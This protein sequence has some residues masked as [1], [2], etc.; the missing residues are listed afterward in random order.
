MIFE[1]ESHLASI[2]HLVVVVLASSKTR[3]QQGSWFV[4]ISAWQHRLP[5]SK[6]IACALEQQGTGIEYTPTRPMTFAIFSP[7]NG[8]SSLS[9]FSGL[10]MSKVK[11]SL[12]NCLNLPMNLLISLSSACTWERDIQRQRKS[13]LDSQPDWCANGNTTWKV[14]AGGKRTKMQILGNDNQVKN[15]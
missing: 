3:E 8:N 1:T 6:N 5:M 9:R 2:Q 13:A 10:Y 15:V 14:I 11:S 12:C 7:R 4:T